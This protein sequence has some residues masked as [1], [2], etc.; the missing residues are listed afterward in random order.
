MTTLGARRGALEA[1]DRILNRG[2]DADDVLRDTV[3]VLGRLY[4]YAAI[5]FVEQDAVVTGPWAGTPG[6]LPSKRPIHYQGLDV[7]WLLVSGAGDEDEEFLE[8]VALVVS[9]YCLVGWDTHGEPW[10]A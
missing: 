9:P 5:G 6:D 10:S 8:R 7:A 2:G 1:L 4:P 3:A